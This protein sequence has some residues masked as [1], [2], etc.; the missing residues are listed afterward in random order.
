MGDAAEDEDEASVFS[1][2]LNPVKAMGGDII[3]CKSKDGQKL[4][5]QATA[6]LSDEG[7]DCMPEDLFV[8]LKMLEERAYIY[9]WDHPDTG[10]IVIP[11][12]LDDI[13]NGGSI[14]IINEYG[15]I[16]IETIQDYKESY[17]G[18]ES[19]Q[20][21][22]MLAMHPCIMNSLSKA[23]KVKVIINRDEYMVDG[24]R[25][26]NLLLKVE[27]R[28]SYLDTNATTSTIRTRLSSLDMYMGTIGSDISKFNAYVKLRLETLKARGEKSNDILNNLFK[29]YKT[30]TDQI[31]VAYIQRKKE[32]YNYGANITPNKI[33]LLAENKHKVLVK[34]SNRWNAPSV[35]EEKIL[36]LQ[37]QLEEL[38]GKYKKSQ[39]AA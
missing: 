28:E 10:I 36:T 25:S 18:E 27:I 34:E 38:Q 15:N 22:N 11:L 6:L 16:P 7:F 20:A 24:F 30:C 14:N 5:E 13:A 26:G 9:D 4:W 1:F 33:M 39:R 12:D 32:E 8:F 2:A 31:F 37:A 19:R 3:N 17:I 23:G 21:Q 29:G 35:Q